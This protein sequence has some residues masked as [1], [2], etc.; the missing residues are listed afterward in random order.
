MFGF[1]LMSAAWAS[2]W[3]LYNQAILESAQRVENGLYASNRG[4]QQA[5]IEAMG[6]LE[7]ICREHAAATAEKK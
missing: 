4:A 5:A 7:R 6:D 2:Y 3:R 1:A